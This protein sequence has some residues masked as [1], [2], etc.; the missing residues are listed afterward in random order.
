MDWMPYCGCYSQS[1]KCTDNA[2]FTLR[3]AGIY[4]PELVQE[5]Y[6]A[7]SEIKNIDPDQRH[8]VPDVAVQLRL[9]ELG[10]RECS[11]KKLLSK[12]RTKE[13]RKES[14]ATA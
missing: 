8:G 1:P 13:K 2:P 7:E 14:N 11:K 12:L 10:T 5:N 6:E 9:K 4:L 3:L